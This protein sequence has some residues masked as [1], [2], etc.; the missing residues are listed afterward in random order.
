NYLDNAS[1]PS[2]TATLILRIDDN[3]NT[4]GGNLFSLD[5]ANINID[6]APVVDLN[7]ATAGTAVTLGYT[8]NDAATAVPPAASITDADSPN[9]N[10]GSLTVHISA[11][12]AT[13]DQLAIQI[14]ATVTI[15]AGVV[16]VSGNAIGTVSG[17]TS[18]ATARAICCGKT[19]S[20][21]RS[22]FGS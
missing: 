16:S 2:S 1:P 10:G 12:G 15:A 4:G 21:A 14:D 17:A 13:E 8:E 22:A 7:G 9:F 19:T 5:T 18:M 11:N 20:P 3:G 6:A